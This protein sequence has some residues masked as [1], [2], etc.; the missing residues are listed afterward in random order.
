MIYLVTT[1]REL[2]ENEIYKIIG[3]DES[4]S[5]LCS[6]SIL[7]A[8]SETLGLDCH[9]GKLLTFQLGSSN[10]EWQIVID[11][12]TIDIRLYKEILE[13]KYL[14][15]QNA[16]FDLQWLYNYNIIP[17]KIYDTMIVEQLLYLGYPKGIISYSLKSIGLRRLNIDID[18]SV[19]GQ[20]QWKGLCPEVIKYAADDV[21]Y[22]C[23]IMKS[24][25]KDCKEKQCL[26][27]AKLE[28]DVVPAMAYLEWCG[29]KL[30]AEKW[31]NK[32]KKDKENLIN[33]TNALNDFIIKTPELKK[34]HYYENS[35]FDEFC[36]ERVTINWDSPAQVVEV[37]K[38][39]GFDTKVQDKKTGVDKDS[40]IEKHLKTQKGIN[41][42]FLDLYFKYQEYSK[43]VSSFG[44][45]HLDSINPI[46]GRLHTIYRQL[47]TSSGRLSCGSQQNNADLERYKKLP[48]G[49]C[50]YPNLQQLPADDVTRSCFV[51]PKD[52]MFVSADFSAEESRL[53]ADIYQDKEFIKEFTEGSG[54]THS[55]FAWIVFNKECKELGCTG[56][57]DVKEKAPKW[58]KAVKAV[59][60]AWMFGA[61]APT[62]AQSANCSI[63]QAQEY[64]N[65]LENGFSGI[66]RFAKEGSK[67]V[68]KYGYINICKYTG[69]KKYWWDHKDWLERQQSFTQEF[70]EDY[71]N[72]HKGTGD[73]IA[74]KVREH[75]QAAAKYDRDARNVV[76][77]GT[78]AI[79]MKESM[80]RLFN[81]IINNNLFNKVHICASVHDEISCDY[82]KEIVD[83]PNILENI[84]EESADKYCKS[85]P[86]PAEA[87]V[88]EYWIH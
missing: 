53:G 46:T 75:F 9:L 45:G 36:G 22:L 7:Q 52:Y 20:I 28:C 69:H 82:P 27:G 23:D 57:Q 86:I 61:A 12:T 47:A 64:I 76:T 62:I 63:E 40:V 30:D 79:I 15:F 77:Q 10:K 31:S 8:D 2:F 66:S 70:W 72:N 58:R 32:M 83:F 87:S 13:S 33:A 71:R 42:E 60:F 4:L 51:A 41:D 39:L 6:E 50:K 43:V 5:L 14:V 19:R 17:R 55:L 34:F 80:T 18:K 24:Q 16:K 37:A 54:D 1:N 21:V 81:W 73:N 56:V 11:C 78:G 67:F 88:G 74:L 65:R 35:L 38:A 3:V 44:Q 49:S 85:L 48:K 29:I 26:L 59:E 68:R 25:L 84:M